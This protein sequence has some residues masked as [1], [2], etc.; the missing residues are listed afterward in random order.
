MKEPLALLVNDIH[1]S[2][3]N[4]NDFQINWDEALNICKREGI[5]DLVIGGDVWTSRSSQT[6]PVLLA[7]Q[8]ALLKATQTYGLNVIIADGNHDKINQESVESY[9]QLFQTISG[10]DVIP[11][12]EA[13]LWEGC[14]F[15]LLV[16]SYFPESGCFLDVLEQAVED[17]LKRNIGL[18]D[19]KKDIILY[20]HEQIHG[21]LGNMEV[22]GELPQEPF[23]D[24]KAVLCGHIHNRIKIKST[25][26]EYVGSSRQ[27]SFGE[28]EAKGYTILYSD[29]ST[30][31]V[32]NQV[33]T[34]YKT[35][36]L[37][38]DEIDGF[39]LEKDSR[40][41]YKIKVSCNEKQAKV[42]DKQKLIEIGF[43]KVEVVAES[44]ISKEVAASGIS[45]KYDKTGIKKEYQNYCDENSIDSRLGIKYLEG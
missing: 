26:I 35:I 44:L 21:S 45:E 9:N 6:L 2:K 32:Q 8:Y 7:V 12:Y 16:I 13:L 5:Q 18:I 22:P 3:D 40:Y 20:L 43:D 23:K 39:Q 38:A 31:F 36:E 1:I 37:N 34:R 10:V 25:P 41:K 4:I 33:N 42:F 27:H 19:S 30:S 15:A 11:D 28:D 17:T 14:D 24:F 29:G